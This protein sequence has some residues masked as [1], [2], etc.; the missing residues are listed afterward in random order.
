MNPREEAAKRK[1]DVLQDEADEAENYTP[2]D[3]P[4]PEKHGI[5]SWGG[6]NKKHTGLGGFGEGEFTLAE[7]LDSKPVNNIKGLAY[8]KDGNRK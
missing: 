6:Y 1:W 5:D 4:L 7:L 8:K 3:V 2:S